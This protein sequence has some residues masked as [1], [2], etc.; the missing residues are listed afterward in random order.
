MPTSAIPRLPITLRVMDDPLRGN[1]RA[2][3]NV[4]ARS[5]SRERRGAPG[6]FKGMFVT[7]C[8]HALGGR[9]TVDGGVE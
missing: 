2:T 7:V 4:S 5:R 8:R 9:P 3:R 1:A 6:C